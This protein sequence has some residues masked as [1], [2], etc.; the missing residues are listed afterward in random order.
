MER[1]YIELTKLK[2]ERQETA[3]FV[4]NGNKF[5]LN[6]KKTVTVSEFRRLFPECRKN[7]NGEA[8]PGPYING[9]GHNY[10][11]NVATL[12]AGESYTV[13]YN[14]YEHET[15]KGKSLRAIDKFLKFFG[16]GLYLKI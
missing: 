5:K 10:D 13:G 7:F 12:P 14:E 4:I 15:G 11:P 2:K 1:K 8:K 3:E 9:Q 6:M 16:N